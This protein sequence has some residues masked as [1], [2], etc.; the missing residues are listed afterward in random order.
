MLDDSTLG[1][2]PGGAPAPL[3]P[4]TAQQA[5]PELP[6]PPAIDLPTNEAGTTKGK[7]PFPKGEEAGRVR[8]MFLRARAAKRPLTREWKKH[9]QV[10]HNRHWRPQAESWQPNPQITQ[11]WPVIFSAV[12]WM[13]D[14]RPTI[15]VTPAPQ[16][17]SP[18]WDEYE[19]AA[20]DMNT[21]LN[22]SFTNYSLDGEITKILWDVYT[23]QIGWCKTVWEPWLADGLG[24]AVFRRV[25]PFTIYPD[26]FARNLQDMAYII[27]AK[28]MT[29]TSL[30]RAYPGA[31]ALINGNYTLEDT[32]EAPHALDE[33]ISPG[34]PRVAMGNVTSTGGSETGTRW[35][36]GDAK[37]QTFDEPVVTVL[38]CWTRF[39]EAEHVDDGTSKV[40]D[41]WWLSVVVNDQVLMSCDAEEVNAWGGHPYDRMV[42][43]ETGELYGPCM[44][45]MLR[46]PQASIGRVLAAIE[47]NLELM[48]NPV[49]VEDPRAKSRNHR[50][51]NRPGQRINAQ[52]NQIAWLNPPQMQPQIAVQ[53]MQFYK[54]EIESISGL[55]AMVRGF[56]PN[57]R[58]SEGVLDSVQD[59]AFVRVRASLREL[60]RMLR[61]VAHKMASTIAEFYTE[62]RHLAIMGPDGQRLT[63][64]LRERHFYTRDSLDPDENVPLRFTL[65]AD[66]GSQLP[67]SRQARAAEAERLFALGAIDVFELLKAKQWPN[68]SIV[69]KRIMEMQAQAGALG[70][71]PGARQRAGR[72]I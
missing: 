41:G 16:P 3:L 1:M 67:T 57:G 7:S 6:P 58:N 70:Q 30:D 27:E 21:L 4:D 54:G 50:I 52:T 12:S 17:F 5:P 25:D 47:Q 29:V 60:E 36:I 43:T 46:S 44:V 72:N 63:M 40:R 32:D 20:K 65:L 14:Q 31:K 64:M 33:S 42:L 71:P 13:T 26:P 69:A 34:T 9:Y 56:S 38:E 51:S 15:E 35:A 28:T 39:H 68:F 49:L 8:E 53:L 2:M 62:P 19:A 24:D 59:A 18:F 10:L 55:S 45:A 37:Q 23:Y 48:G 61:G 22:A 66:A 11:V